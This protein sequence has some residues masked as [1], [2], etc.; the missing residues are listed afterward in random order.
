MDRYSNT[1][2]LNQLNL[3]LPQVRVT[4]SKR[5]AIEENTANIKALQNESADLCIKLTQVKSSIQCYSNFPSN[6]K[7]FS[8]D[9]EARKTLNGILE[10]LSKRKSN[11]HKRSEEIHSKIEELRAKSEELAIEIS[12]ENNLYSSIVDFFNLYKPG[13]LEESNFINEYCLEYLYLFINFDFRD[14]DLFIF[15]SLHDLAS[16]K[17][18]LYNYYSIDGM[19]NI[20]YYLHHCRPKKDIFKDLFM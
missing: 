17:Q 11:I 9:S 4:I 5:R 6:F 16:F 14:R 10:D 20:N 7:L 19:E 3:I 8:E 12:I 18:K 1:F 2:R 15:K 13:F